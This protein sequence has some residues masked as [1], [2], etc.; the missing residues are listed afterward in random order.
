MLIL[1]LDTS[2]RSGS[3][4]V[5]RDGVV[6]QEL[7]GDAA[8][9]H[10]ERLPTDLMKLLESAGVDLHDV[11]LFA[12][13]AG[14]GSFTG[15]RVGI[16]TIQGLAVAGGRPVV[17]ISTLEALARSAVRDGRKVAA[18]MDA[19][20]GEVFGSLYAPDGRSILIDASSAPPEATL[21]AWHV[22]SDLRETTFTG[23]GAVRYRDRI[24][25]T[26]PDATVEPPALLAGVIGHIASLE[27][28][29]AVLPHAVV[30]VYIRRSDAELA[31]ERRRTQGQT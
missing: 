14:P 28:E 24:T 23:D 1:S 15:L 8:R 19:Q 31:R 16:A 13:A 17:A 5:V 7:A 22:K 30:P 25:A 18:W 6:I 10:G 21:S 9:T 3:A 4:A 12:V 29:R 2:T 20:R 11:E 27:P 26:L